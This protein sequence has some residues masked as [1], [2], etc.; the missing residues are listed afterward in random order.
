[1]LFCLILLAASLI[2]AETKPALDSEESKFLTLINQYRERN[3][4]PA[5]QASALL[6]KSSEWMSNDMATKNYFSHTDSQGRNPFQ[7]M[8]DFGYSH[9]PAAENIGAGHATAEAVLKQ[10]QTACDP[11]SSGACTYAHRKNMLNPSYKVIGIGRAHNRASK[12]GW[13]WTTDFGGVV[14]QLL[15]PKEKPGAKSE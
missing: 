2:H 12:F 3:G 4:A 10:W 15:N 9:S 8:A 5:L 11:D 14:D 1:M 7:R 6:E 13:Y